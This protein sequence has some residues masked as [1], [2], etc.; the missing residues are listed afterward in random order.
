MGGCH[1]ERNIE[2]NVSSTRGFKLSRN[3]PLRTRV[4]DSRRRKS[5]VDQDRTVVNKVEARQGTTRAGMRYVLGGGLVLVVIVFALV[6]LF[7]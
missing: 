6:W 2:P 1:L 4:D 5:D 7:G 3:L